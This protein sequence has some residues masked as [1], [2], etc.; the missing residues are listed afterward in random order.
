MEIRFTAPA[1][2]DLK[3]LRDYLEPLSPSGFKNVVS[4]IEKTVKE[5]PGS[6]SRGFTIRV[7]S[8]W[9]TE[10]T[11]RRYKGCSC[12]VALLSRN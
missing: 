5:I 1:Q 4:D 6:I 10:V 12:T 8:P 7:A 2:Q 11:P 9:T 3:E